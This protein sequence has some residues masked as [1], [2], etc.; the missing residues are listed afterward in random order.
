MDAILQ[1]SGLCKKY[2]GFSLDDVSFSLPYGCI[3]G[4]V[5]ENGAGKSTTIKAVLNLIRRDRGE[6]QV[7]GKD[8]IQN[9]LEI[10]EQIGVVFDS[11]N[12]PEMI[13]PLDVGRMMKSVYRQ[14]DGDQY[15]RY[16]SQFQ[17]PAKKLVKDLSRGMKM[18]LAIAVAL[19]HNARLLLLDEATSGLDPIVRDEILDILLE[20][21]Q[22]ESRGV[23]FSS[24]I[25]GDLE[26]IADY[27]TFIHQ[28]KI[29]LSEPKDLLLEK[30]GVVQCTKEAL[31]GLD[32]SAVVGVRRHQFGVEALVK[33]EKIPGAYTVGKASI[34]DIMLFIARGEHQ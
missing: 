27:V 29:L 18:K 28:G 23:L 24:H 11:L 13:R 7:F 34:E 33:K 25:T 8:N 12:L 31:A 6:I 22:D 20:F 3:M 32:K 1:V 15:T 2:D 5:G 21:I 14:W 17:L 19:S 4:F 30:Y 16:L 10:K 9:E 26:K